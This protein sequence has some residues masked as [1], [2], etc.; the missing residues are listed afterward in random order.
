MP[1]KI[2]ETQKDLNVFKTFRHW[3]G[4]NKIYLAKIHRHAFYAHNETKKLD[5]DNIE[6]I[7]RSFRVKFIAS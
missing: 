5:K 2:R 4:G 6:N 1:V 3:L 7:F